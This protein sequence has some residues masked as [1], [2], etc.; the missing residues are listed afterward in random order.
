[1]FLQVKKKGGFAEFKKQGWNEL[2]LELVLLLNRVIT[3]K[4]AAFQQDH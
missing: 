1:M 4:S 2:S 3:Q